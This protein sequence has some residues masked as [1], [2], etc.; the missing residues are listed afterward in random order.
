MV[1]AEYVRSL[2]QQG[3]ISAIEFKQEDTK[4]DCIAR[5]L[6]A[7]SNYLGGTLLLGISDEGKI[8]GVLRKVWEEWLANIARENV[9]P[10]INLKIGKIQIDGKTVYVA[11][12]PKGTQKPYQTRDGKFWIRV[13]STNRIATQGELMRL[14]QQSGMIH[15]D[16][17]PVERTNKIAL[18]FNKVHE[19]FRTS[20]QINFNEL[21]EQEQDKILFNSDILLEE[22]GKLS[23][24]GLLIFGKDPQRF[25]PQSAITLAIFK[26]AE[27]DAELNMKKEIS[28]TLPEQIDNVSSLL[29]LHLPNP[30]TIKGMKRE[31]EDIIHQK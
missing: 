12:I 17:N 7:F 10:A 14:F 31:E 13:G 15:Y 22:E 29:Q 23:V 3:E 27:L 28:G 11:E 1:S 21:E 16:L 25:L 18:N 19:Y 9:V 8:E 26:G 20:Y 2:L 6:V 4:P 30:S 5:E 24:S